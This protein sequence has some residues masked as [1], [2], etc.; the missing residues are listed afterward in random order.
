VQGVPLRTYRRKDL[1]EIDLS[2]ASDSVRRTVAV[3]LNEALVTVFPYGSSFITVLT[4][5]DSGTV[6]DLLHQ[7]TPV[8]ADAG[9]GD[10]SR[11]SLYVLE[12]SMID[13]GLT[14]AVE[15]NWE[16]LFR[17]VTDYLAW[18]LTEDSQTEER[19]DTSPLE[20]PAALFPER[21]VIAS[22]SESR[23]VARVLEHLRTMV[24]RRGGDTTATP[25]TRV[26][27][28]PSVPIVTTEP[29]DESGVAAND[30]VIEPIASDVGVEF[31]QDARA[32]A[33]ETADV[34]PSGGA[35][36]EAPIEIADQ[37]PEIPSPSHEMSDHA[38]AEEDR[39]S[40]DA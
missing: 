30:Q 23:F 31:N 38:T 22:N 3:L 37:E 35:P 4:E 21:P 8:G 19:R 11:Q 17:V 24:A 29:T 7:F 9:P 12:D 16:Q 5:D 14:S 32:E 18:N 27:P 33:T 28:S 25:P 20:D 26:T 36:D 1:L 39:R 34:E 2:G 15:R 40:D 13:L 6:G 10:P